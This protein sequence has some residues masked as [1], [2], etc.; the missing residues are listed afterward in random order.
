MFDWKT[1]F[2]RSRTKRRF[3]CHTAPRTLCSSVTVSF[4]V[5]RCKAP[6]GLFTAHA[7]HKHVALLRCV[8]APSPNSAEGVISW[9]F[10]GK[11]QPLFYSP[12]GTLLMHK[13]LSREVPTTPADNCYHHRRLMGQQYAIHSAP[14][15]NTS[16]SAHCETRYTH[17]PA[18]PGTPCL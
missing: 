2:C 16:I 13:K 6:A 12:T 4:L 8:A 15:K 11:S 7:H 3:V 1:V 10:P 14:N 17:C 9:R 18:G 5:R